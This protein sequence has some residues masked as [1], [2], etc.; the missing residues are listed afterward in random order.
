MDKLVLRNVSKNYGQ[1]E[2]VKDI[3]FAVHEKEFVSIVGPSGC[4]K[5]S[6]LRM[7]AGLE[8]ITDGDIYLDGKRINDSRARDRNIALAFES[9]ALYPHM[10]AAQ[11]LAFPLKAR[12]IHRSEASDRVRK[13]LQVVNLSSQKEMKPAELSGGQQQRLSLG[14]ALIR[15]ASIYLLDEPLS[16]LDTQERAELRVQLQR[17]QKLNGLTFVLVTHD[18]LE[19]IEMSDRIIVMNNGRIQQIGTPEELYTDPA[20]LFVA[21]FI[22]EPPMNFVH[23]TLMRASRNVYEVRSGFEGFKVERNGVSSL[24]EHLDQKILQGIR[25]ADVVLCESDMADAMEGQIFSYEDLGDG[26]YVMIDRGDARLLASV[27]GGKK[28][29]A[30]DRVSFRFV[31]ER[32][33]FFSSTTG[34]RI[35]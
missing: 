4:G 19:A 9:Y 1:V 7:I 35:R 27:T 32:V 11:N 17:I 22:G 5:S 24:E 12:R 28:F 14:R 6:T 29:V 18:Q 25:P 23:G 20:N 8:A 26:G 33:Y 21:D 13:T 34:D 3:S 2:A 15:S 30:G 10:T 16:H 31:K